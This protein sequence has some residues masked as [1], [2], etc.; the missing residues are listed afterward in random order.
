MVDAPI[1]EVPIQRNT[2]E[3]NQE[4]NDGNIPEDWKGKPD[5]LSQKDVDA[6]WVTHNGKNYYGYKDHIK[7]DTKT[8]LITC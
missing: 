2:R 6:K 5:K 4:L 8:K 7:A 1:V 3:E